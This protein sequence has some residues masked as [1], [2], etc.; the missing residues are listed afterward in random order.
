VADPKNLQCG[1]FIIYHYYTEIAYLCY[2]AS[3]NLGPFWYEY[4][5]KKTAFT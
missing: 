5:Y 2:Y 4:I 3:L 1:R